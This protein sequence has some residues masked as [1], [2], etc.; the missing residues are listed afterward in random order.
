MVTKFAIFNTKLAIT[1]LA[2]EIWPWYLHLLG[3]L[4][5]GQFKDVSQ[6]LL[7]PTPVATV[8]KICEFQHIV[9][10]DWAN[11]RDITQ[12]LDGP[13]KPPTRYRYLGHIS[14][15]SWV[16]ANI[17]LKFPNFR[18]HGNRCQSEQ[19]LTNTLKLAFPKYPYQVQ[20]S[21]SYLLCKL[22]YG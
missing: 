7:R 19:S 20:L 8:T 9:G 2:L 1:Q 13:L 17:V 21:R 5:D 11:V 4:G 15:T 6:T 18:Y 12:V 16:I 22:S 3:L 14:Y 10:Y